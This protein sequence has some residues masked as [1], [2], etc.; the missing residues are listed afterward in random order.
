MERRKTV[1]IESFKPAG[2]PFVEIREGSLVIFSS[3]PL[4]PYVD[5]RYDDPL[6]ISKVDEKLAGLNVSVQRET[7]QVMGR[8]IAFITISQHMGG[9]TILRGL[10]EFLKEEAGLDPAEN[11]T[12]VVY[13]LRGDDRAL[14]IV[15]KTVSGQR[16]QFHLE[17]GN[18][19]FNSVKVHSNG[20]LTT[21]TTTESEVTVRIDFRPIFLPETQH[22]K[23]E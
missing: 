21:R 1:T 7:D 9:I 8:Y 23:S 20:T 19:N 16:K 18:I 22:P 3:S 15:T 11:T 17:L 13:R 12:L 5:S 14:V 10:Y 6:F 4:Y 2:D